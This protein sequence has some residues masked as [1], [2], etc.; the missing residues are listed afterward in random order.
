MSY[1]EHYQHNRDVIDTYINKRSNTYYSGQI[2]KVDSEIN[3]NIKK[4]INDF[5]ED[6]YA[7]LNDIGVDL[8]ALNYASDTHKKSAERVRHKSLATKLI[9]RSL[10][11]GFWLLIIG[12]TAYSFIRPLTLSP[13]EKCIENIETS[14]KEEYCNADGSLGSR[15]ADEEKKLKAECLARGPQW[16]YSID[17]YRVQYNSRQEC[18]DAGEETTVPEGGVYVCRDDG[19]S[20]YISEAEILKETMREVCVIKGNIS[21]NSGERIY[22]V[23]GQAYYDDTTISESYGERWF[24]SEESAQ[25]AGWRKAYE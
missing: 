1:Y 17:C 11:A 23:P 16:D 6:Q 3:A 18:I 14:Y 2:N 21:F 25:A 10:I 8:A 15:T 20:H 7:W 22:H 9:I 13:Y 24:C 19:K 5:T 4:G 12:G